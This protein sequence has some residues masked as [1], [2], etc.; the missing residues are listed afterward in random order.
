[1]VDVKYLS[2][3]I[4]VNVMNEG[5]QKS[6]FISISIRSATEIYFN[7]LYLLFPLKAIH[8]ISEVNTAGYIAPLLNVKENF[9]H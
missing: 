2:F 5:F 8:R 7:N 4:K 6:L 3:I 9:F 1:M